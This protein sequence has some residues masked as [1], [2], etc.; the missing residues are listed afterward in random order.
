MISR[1]AEPG[2]LEE[3][4][5]KLVGR[6]AANAPLAVRI[7]KRTLVRLMDFRDAV[8]HDDLEAEVRRVSASDDAREG[9]A[10]RLA[11]RTPEFR[12]A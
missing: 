7:M 10:A 11:R 2:D 8:P 6:L 9:I 3:E 4:A 1:V 5:Q 12:G